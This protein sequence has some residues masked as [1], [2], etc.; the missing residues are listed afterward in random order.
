M[1]GGLQ[2]ARS[3]MHY[4]ELFRLADQA[5]LLIDPEFSARRLEHFLVV[6]GLAG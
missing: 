3:P 5:R 6:T 1:L 2:S 4:A